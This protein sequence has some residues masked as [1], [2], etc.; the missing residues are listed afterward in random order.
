MRSKIAVAVLIGLFGFPG[1]RAQSHTSPTFGG[2]TMNDAS[3]DDDI[4]EDADGDASDGIDFSSDSGATFYISQPSCEL[5]DPP[6]A[7]ADIRRA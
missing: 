5:D 1:R 3:E 6:A 2:C 4:D 7:L